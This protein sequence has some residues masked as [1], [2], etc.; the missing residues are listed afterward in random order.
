M[1]TV[2]EKIDSEE[3]QIDEFSIYD[4]YSE[5]IHNKKS[6]DSSF[7]VSIRTFRSHYQMTNYSSYGLFD[8]VKYSIT[9]PQQ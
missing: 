8:F 1:I 4:L 2:K 3:L 9:K 7:T 5:T 6:S